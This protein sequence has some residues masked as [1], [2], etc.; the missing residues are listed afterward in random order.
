MPFIGDGLV[1]FTFGDSINFIEDVLKLLNNTLSDIQRQNVQEKGEKNGFIE[2]L[3]ELIN[4]LG[5]QYG[6][7][8]ISRHLEEFYSDEKI[9][10][11]ALENQAVSLVP[12]LNY[13]DSVTTNFDHVLEYAYE[14]AGI[15]PSIATP[16]DCNVLNNKLR[17]NSEAAN[18][19][20]LFL[21]LIH[22]SEPTR[23]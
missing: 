2:A 20:L 17:S 19:A 6:E 5:G 18:K 8:V 23:P 14:L 7:N 21:S 16:Y 9:D 11:Y 10:P 15:N 13:G 4:I 3:D 1:K 12:L 22:I